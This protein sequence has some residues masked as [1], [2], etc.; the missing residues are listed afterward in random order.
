MAGHATFADKTK[1]FEHICLPDAAQVT[2]GTPSLSDPFRGI[3]QDPGASPESQF[4]ATLPLNS[5]T[6]FGK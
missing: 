4:L 6:V 3:C 1:V 5:A 2:L